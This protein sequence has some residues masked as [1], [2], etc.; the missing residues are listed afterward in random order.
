M[1]RSPTLDSAIADA[2][3]ITYILHRKVGDVFEADGVKLRLV[4]ALDDSIFQSELIV[5]E[6]NFTRAFPDVQGFRY[7][8]IMGR[9]R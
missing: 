7:F 1:S 4:A 2:N 5:S 3:S 6:Q 9:Q 8:L